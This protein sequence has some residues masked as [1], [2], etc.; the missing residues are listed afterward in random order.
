MRAPDLCRATRRPAAL[1]GALVALLLL[2]VSAPVSAGEPDGELATRVVVTGLFEPVYAASPPGDPSRLLILTQRGVIH[3]VKDGVLEATP[4]LDLTGT[5]A[6]EGFNGLLGIAFHPDY[7]NN[8]EFFLH[9]ADG[10]G[11]QPST[12]LVIARFNVTGSGDTAAPAS[13][14]DILVLPYPTTPG[15]HLGGWIGFG[16]DGFLYIPLGDG[17]TTGQEQSGG[18]RSQDPASPWGK[19]LRIDVDGDDF[20]ADPDR[21]YAIPAD[22]PFVGLGGEEAAWNLGLRQPYRCDFDE[23]TGD[24]W[25]AE[26][27]WHD[28]EEIDFIPGTSTGGENF[29]WVCK[30]GTLCL[31]AV[32]CDCFL[33]GL[34]DPIYEYAHGDGCSIIGGAVY[35]GGELPGMD[36]RFVYADWCTNR[37]WSVGQ[38]GGVAVDPREHTADLA[39]PTGDFTNIVAISEGANGELYIV[40]RDTVYEIIPD[41]WEDLGGG[42][43]G[44]NGRVT[45]TGSGPLTPGSLN[46]ITITDAAPNA[47]MLAWIALNPG[48]PF[49]A[50]GQGGVVHAIPFNSQLFFFSDA[51]GSW[52]AAS[53]WPSGVPAGTEVT[54]QFLV[55]DLSVVWGITMSNGLRATTP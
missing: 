19:T 41:R 12:E 38:A 29:G 20:P 31:S 43:N 37:I 18:L 21:D 23:L 25:I 16:P 35:R 36:G 5:I 26:V 55:E 22:N 45:A 6:D 52:S 1:S 17:G 30:E 3:L 42:T 39:P 11:L 8:G 44:I 24:F 47:L 32:S 28:R 13:R 27:G 9:F 4:F 54:F 34:T 48:P 51:N 53:P 49:P 40:D 2:V 50:L 15:H 33:S 7:A 10:P 14:D 46:P